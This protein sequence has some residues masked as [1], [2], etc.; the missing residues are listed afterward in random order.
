MCVK[1]Q[2]IQRSREVERRCTHSPS[3][4][5]QSRRRLGLRAPAP[6]PPDTIRP[7]RPSPLRPSG[8]QTTDRAS[9][10]GKLGNTLVLA[11]RV[12]CWCALLCTTIGE[13]IKKWQKKGE[14]SGETND[15]ETNKTATLTGAGASDPSRQHTPGGNLAGELEE[16]RFPGARVADQQAVAFATAADT[17]LRRPAGT[18]IL[19]GMRDA[20]MR[21]RFH[22]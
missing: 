11:L 17:I 20:G 15:T 2:Q 5:R 9:G 18:A 4:V 16:L 6:R 21:R 8:L 1:H 12:H 10:C 22:L 13:S 14:K 7:Q 3:S 19:S